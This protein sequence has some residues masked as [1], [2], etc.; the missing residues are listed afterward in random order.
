[1]G[2][3]GVSALIQHRFVRHIQALLPRRPRLSAA[4]LSLSSNCLSFN[5]SVQPIP[6]SC[7]FD[8]PNLKIILTLTDRGK[9]GLQNPN[10]HISHPRLILIDY[11]KIRTLVL[12]MSMPVSEVCRERSVAEKL[13]STTGYFRYHRH[14]TRRAQFQFDSS[15]PKDP[16]SQESACPA[17]LSTVIRHGSYS[18]FLFQN[19]YFPVLFELGSIT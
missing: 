4:P 5:Q 19:Y 6:V 9:L 11:P 3:E 15:R 8:T 18:A 17:V 7:M 12:R 14:V 16:R 10:L 13:V 2:T 1:M